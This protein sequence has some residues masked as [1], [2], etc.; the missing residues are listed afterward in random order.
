MVASMFAC[1][2]L[3]STVSTAGSPGMV[4]GQDRHLD[5]ETPTNY[6]VLCAQVDT[7]AGSI[8]DVLP[9]KQIRSLRYEAG[10][11][12]TDRFVRQR[13]VEH[14]LKSNIELSV[15][16]S[17]GPSLHV[18]VP[19]VNVT[20]SAPVATHIFGSADVVRS[21]RSDYDFEI[22]DSDRIVYAKSYSFVFSDTVKESQIAELESGSYDFLRG[23]SDPG[24][25]FDTMLQ[26]ILF[27]ASAAV[28]I[29]L[30]FT[31]RGS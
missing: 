28:V 15:S 17:R 7:L 3:W 21:I 23:K 9:G 24:G 31:L 6:N 16:S 18:M 4:N 19:S 26:P 30:F 12:P 14:L 25:F 22:A 2:F 8:A 5:R 10:T 1:V 27:I 29:Y 11:R 20:Y 13:I